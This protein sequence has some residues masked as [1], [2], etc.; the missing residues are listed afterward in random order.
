MPNTRT[1]WL[2]SST[3]DICKTQITDELYDARTTSGP[4][5]TMCKDCFKQHGIGK[6]GI[7]YGQK[8]VLHEGVFVKV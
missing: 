7:G 8:Y 1:A 2:G 5:A 6:L 4:W 3:C